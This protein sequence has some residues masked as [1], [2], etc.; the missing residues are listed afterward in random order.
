MFFERIN[1]TNETIMI[2]KGKQ[3][4]CKELL[5]VM[6]QYS[7]VS[8]KKELLLLL[9]DNSVQTVAAYLTALCSGHSVMLMS[10]STNKDLLDSLVRAYK[11]KWIVSELSFDGYRMQDNRYE[12]ISDVSITIHPDLAVLLSTS[13]TTGSQ[14][15]VRLSYNNLQSNAEAIVDYLKIGADERAVLNLPLSYSYGLSILNSHLQVGAA[16][17]LTEESV[18]SKT[19]WSFL[20]E[21]RATSLSGVPFTYQMLNRIGF[22]KMELPYLK[23]LTQA[24][25]RLDSRLVQLFG[26][27]ALD[28]NKRFFVM[29]GQTEAAPRISY[30]PPEKVLEKS[31]SIGIA[32]PGGQLSLAPETNELI[33]K[34]PNVMMGYA[35]SLADLA[36]GDECH[37]VLYTGDTAE[38]DRDGYYTITGRMKRFVKLFGLRI[39]LDDVERKVELA[40]RKSVA[41]IGN[42]DKLVVVIETEADVEV[43][44][45]VLEMT[46]K[47]HKSSYKIVAIEAIPTMVNGKVDYKALKDELM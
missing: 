35:E 26:Q 47:L 45:E 3:Y 24:G 14:K 13:G 40:T 46:Y 8:E 7:F 30:I 25:G 19:F 42:D 28:N 2:T 16:I 34:G 23:T 17:L 39:N 5:D 6:E 32:V 43:V 44:K 20:E 41:C 31:G 18:V 29:Y 38:V 15:F 21:Q 27:Y 12:R 10:M 22:L 9:C 1:P 33:Y 11:P 4:T 37:G 36:K